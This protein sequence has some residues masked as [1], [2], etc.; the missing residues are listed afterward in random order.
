MQFKGR[1][2]QFDFEFALGSLWSLIFMEIPIRCPISCSAEW[3]REEAD[4]ACILSTLVHLFVVYYLPVILL[5]NPEGLTSL[6][7]VSRETEAQEWSNFSKFTQCSCWQAAAAKSLQSCPTLCVP[8]DGSPPGSAVPGILQARTLEWLAISFSNAWKWKVKVKLL[9]HIWLS[10]P[11][12]YSPPGS[13]V[14]G[15]FQARVLEW[16]AIAFSNWQ[17]SWPIIKT[18]LEGFPGGPVIKN[19][20]CNARDTSLIP[21]PGRFPMPQST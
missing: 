21:G 11:M 12:D 3:R 2:N 16:G 15:I 19:S 9:S 20:L 18:D 17:A 5:D 1:G 4:V 6:H 14:R 8:I 13:S 7:F 10:D